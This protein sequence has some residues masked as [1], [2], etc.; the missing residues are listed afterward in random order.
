MRFA[1]TRMGCKRT[2]IVSDPNVAAKAPVVAALFAA[3]KKADESIPAPKGRGPRTRPLFPCEA[4]IS[5]DRS[6]GP[7]IALLDPKPAAAG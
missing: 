4:A 2:I 6:R 5:G 7:I 3:R 1:A